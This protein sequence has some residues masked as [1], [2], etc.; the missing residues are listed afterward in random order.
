VRPDAKGRQIE[1]AVVPLRT[2]GERLGKERII[3]QTLVV[4]E[5]ID[6]RYSVVD[7]FLMKHGKQVKPNGK[8]GD[9]LICARVT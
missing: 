4:P 8:P 6:P 5:D 9:A 7:G 1:E 2:S 3:R